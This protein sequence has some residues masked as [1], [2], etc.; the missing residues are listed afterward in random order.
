[1]ADLRVELCGI[2]LA[3][4]L[5]VSSGPLTYGAQGIRRCFEAGASAAV[6]KTLSRVAAE[7]P[8]PHIT[9]LGKGTMLNTEKWADLG[10]EQWMEVEFPALRDADG[11]VIASMGHTVDVVEEIAP[12]VAQAEAV[13]MI[14]VV[15]YVASDMVRMVEAVKRLSG[16]PVLAKMSPNWPDVVEIADA[17]VAAG[18]D[19]ITAADSLGPTLHVDIETAMPA[20]ESDYGHAWMSGAAIRPVI[21]RIVA[22]IC[23]R[24]PDIP[25]VATG[26]VSNAKDV[27][28]M[29]MLG[30][31]AVGVHT[32]PMLRGIGWFGKTSNGLSRWLD[33]HGY[34]S[35]TATK[36]LAQ[37]NLVEGEDKRPLVFRYDPDTCTEC[38]RCVVV[39]AYEA[40]QLDNKVMDL[41]EDAC[42][43]CGLCVAVCP[44]GALTATK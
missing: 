42:R 24:H 14:E 15:S 37:P 11:V 21:A 41:D 19:G 36:G 32:A 18:A 35:I 23:R 2:E 34:A 31:S 33:G 9:D 44:T 16:L 10:V 39:C 28:E 8:T 7:N 25:V 27:V 22:D 12:I 3:N 13:K 38:V 5:I 17:C 43:S 26:G 29:F 6:T 20:L 40:R 4:P 30:A 1:M